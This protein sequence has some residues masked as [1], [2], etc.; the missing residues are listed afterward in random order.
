[1]KANHYRHHQHHLVRQTLHYLNIKIVLQGFTVNLVCAHEHFHYIPN[2]FRN[3]RRLEQQPNSRLYSLSHVVFL[4]I[5]NFIDVINIYL[6]N[7]SKKRVYLH[8]T[9]SLF[10]PITLF[11]FSDTL[12]LS[13]SLPYPIYTKPTYTCVFCLNVFHCFPVL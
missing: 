3:A 7:I 1:M 5:E 8:S 10:A 9:T 4:H 11:L 12:E 13:V 2:L 6:Q